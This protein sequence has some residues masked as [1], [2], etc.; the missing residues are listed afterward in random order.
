MATTAATT[1]MAAK[2]YLLRENQDCAGSSPALRTNSG[3][4]FNRVC[5]ADSDTASGGPGEESFCRGRAETGGC[6]AEATAEAETPRLGAMS[7]AAGAADGTALATSRADGEEIGVGAEGCR[8][9]GG[10]TF[11]C[12]RH[13]FSSH[14]TH[15][16]RPA[17]T[18]KPQ[19]WHWCRF[20]STG[21][22]R[23]WSG[24]LGC[25]VSELRVLGPID[26]KRGR[27]GG[28]GVGVAGLYA[29][30]EACG[31]SRTWSAM[32]EHNSEDGGPL[33]S[34]SGS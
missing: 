33:V 24:W 25:G 5:G 1:K 7:G 9:A 2:I 34:G 30:G 10:G 3:S 19:A 14:S 8:G 17:E 28:A 21:G 32:P 18:G 6:T 31:A 23:L 26:Q 13:F 15:R 29:C 12:P 11:S 27:G 16:E 4:G 20:L 22:T